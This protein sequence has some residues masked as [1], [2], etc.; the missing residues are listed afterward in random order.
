ME[1]KGEWG[2]KSY[3]VSSTWVGQRSQHSMGTPGPMGADSAQ[4]KAGS[5]PQVLESDE[6]E[7]SL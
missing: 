5:V 2:P 7:K 4:A 3:G 1:G 6:W